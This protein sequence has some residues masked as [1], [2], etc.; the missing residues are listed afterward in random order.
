MCLV[1]VVMSVFN[2]EECL[3]DAI[4]SILSQTFT[5]F[6][7]IIINDGST[8]E[9]VNIINS[10]N[11]ERIVLIDQNN[12][13]LTAS[14]NVG[15][16]QS[17]GKYIARQDAD[18]ISY[19]SRLMEQVKV[20]ANNS[21][22]IVL[23]TRGLIK[24]GIHSYNSP[25]YSN[26][27]IKHKIKLRNVLIHSSVM[28]RKDIFESVGFYNEKYLTSQDHDAWIRLSELG[29][30]SMIDKVL[31]SREIRN[32]SISKTKLLT[33]CING[34]KIRHNKISL[35]MNLFQATFQFLSNS[36]P[37]SIYKYIRSLKSMSTKKNKRF[38][39]GE[40]WINFSKHLS[41]DRIESAINSLRSSLSVDHLNGLTFLDVG[42]GSGLFSLA[43]KRLGAN[44]I[45]FDY[46]INCVECTKSI[47]EN[48]GVN[49]DEN[50]MIKTGSILDS[51]F[52]IDFQDIDVVYSWGV[53]HHTGDMWLAFDNIYN[54]PKRNG[55]LLFI[56]IYNDQGF[57]SKYWKYVKKLYNKSK[58]GKWSMIFFHFPYLFIA[59]YLVG[60]FKINTKIGRGMD[61]WH[62]L[63]DWLGGYPFEVAKPEAVTD[64][65]YKKGYC[66]IKMTTVSNKMGCNEFIFKRL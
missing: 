40:N 52:L 30:I 2:E 49:D 15:I 61:L 54:L 64:Y 60:L 23:A 38:M 6:E 28:I 36:I 34:F 14:L 26:I 3:T 17:K 55:G 9:S 1:S 20:F 37:F 47:K 50:W 63:L 33:Q 57:I 62:D 66:L 12:K 27:D 8:D 32:N 35:V 11:D 7:F 53:L 13:G 18:D 10:Y 39:F 51:S 4:D 65:F 44:V 22:L 41:G 29:E 56:A 45:S 42:S 19:P 48:F 16:V 21:T 43:A 31:V 59:R 58:F 25:F 46:D 24:N 5:D